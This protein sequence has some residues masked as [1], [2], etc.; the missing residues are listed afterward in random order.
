MRGH[1]T[2]GTWRVVDELPS[3]HR[4]IGSRWVFVIQR[5]PAGNITRFKARLVARGDR[6]GDES[7]DAERL[8][9]PVASYSSIRTV[10]ALA[11]QAGLQLSQFDVSQAYLNGL[12]KEE[13]YMRLPDGTL[14]RLV[15]ALY[16]L[17][18][19]GREW[20]E[21]AHDV[22][23]SLGFHRTTADPCVYVGTFRDRRMLLCLYVDDM[24][25]A[26]PVD[27]PVHDLIDELRK[28]WKL[29]DVASSEL[30]VGLRIRQNLD[31][32]TVTLDQSHYA[33]KILARYGYAH[34]N[35]TQTPLPGNLVLSK[36]DAPQTITE[37]EATAAFPYRSVVGAVMWL[38]RGTR[39][40]LAFAA[41]YLARFVAH[42]GPAHVAAAKH[43]LRYVKGT[44]DL[45]VIYRRNGSVLSGTSDADW[46]GCLD[47]RRSTTGYV[48]SLADGP[49]S[50]SS[51]RQHTVALSSL[52]AEYQAV[53]SAAR[54]AI[55]LKRLLT[56]LGFASL[57]ERPIIRVDNEG[58]I[59]LARHPSNHDRTKHIDTLHHFVRD[60]VD[61]RTLRLVRVDTGDNTSDL[62][63]KSL[64][65]ILYR[66][67]RDALVYGIPR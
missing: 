30:Y 14:V 25:L 41:G 58:A 52:E 16:G 40:D 60:Q 38:A 21:A 22:L 55:W 49:I 5:N 50:W 15:K 28:H 36:E 35:P 56:N 6:Q 61:A 51:H 3:G 20:N 9:A 63:T 34:C 32:G 2:N 39:P 24:Q 62:L 19:A 37:S 13:I 43:L 4:A 12:V 54:E 67:H 10:A 42:P 53:A 47:L 31:E 7:F 29:K 17:K 23:L 26:A 33:R 45:G 65:V 46:A 59:A 64:R 57:C 8:H 44:L 18:Q 11:A 1:E 27:A 66:R 48:F